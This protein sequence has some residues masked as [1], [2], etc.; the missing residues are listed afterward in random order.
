MHYE[1]HSR[2]LKILIAMCCGL[3]N[4]CRDAI[5][6]EAEKPWKGMKVAVYCPTAVEYKNEIFHCANQL[7]L[8]EEDKVSPQP[9]QWS[10]KKVLQGLDNHPITNPIDKDF[11]FK[12]LEEQK[13]NVI[14]AQGE[15]QQELDAIEK[16]YR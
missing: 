11:I 16:I 5:F 4:N 3:H 7:E 1:N 13:G 2:V 12:T 6:L 10:L 14:L 15:R 9:A 8:S